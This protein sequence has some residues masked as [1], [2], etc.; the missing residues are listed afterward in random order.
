MRD[1]KRDIISMRQLLVLMFTGLTAVALRQVPGRSAAATG[2]EGAWLAPLIAL[3]AVL[4]LCWVMISLFRN[5]PAHWGLGEV[6]QGVLGLKIG[7]ALILLYIV[8]ALWILGSG[9]A[10]CSERLGVLGYSVPGRAAFL[11][12]ALVLT[13]GMAMGKLSAFARASEIFFLVLTVGV[14]FVLALACFRVQ[15]GNLL[16]VRGAAWK[17]GAS[18]AAVAGA[19]V[20]AAFLMGQIA[21]KG[22]QQGAKKLVRWAVAAMLFLLALHVICIGVFGW[23]VTSRQRVPLYEA[24]KQ[25]GIP[26]AFHRVEAVIAALLVM[27]DVTLFGWI[28]FTIGA[29]GRSFSHRLK[30]KGVVPAAAGIGAGIAIC[31]VLWPAAAKISGQIFLPILSL[32][33]GFFVP[34]VIAVVKKCRGVKQEASLSCGT[35]KEKTEDIVV[36]KEKE[37]RLKKEGKKC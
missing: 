28:L 32:V 1:M 23:Q 33:L 19:G 26:G 34:T 10:Q 31:F 36:G 18:V 2:G 29:M 13:A 8:W 7:K 22:R 9:I 6:Y 25:V 17:G 27:S 20:P 24:A 4:L 37:K 15:P 11:L 12:A 14:V 30:R 35:E 3:P 16:P 5:V 21:E